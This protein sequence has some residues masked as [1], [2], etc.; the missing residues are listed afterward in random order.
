LSNWLGWIGLFFLI[1]SGI[2]YL[3]LA[4]KKPN[5]QGLFSLFFVLAQLNYFIAH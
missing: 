5:M 4:E 2:T 3:T 1:Y